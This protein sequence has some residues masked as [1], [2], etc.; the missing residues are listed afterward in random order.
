MRQHAQRLY[1]RIGTKFDTAAGAAVVIICINLFVLGNGYEYCG[2]VK[3]SS[4]IDKAI[5][6]VNT[7]LG[8]TLAGFLHIG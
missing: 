5:V 2:S 8:L 3:L 4:P 6:A 7:G 1:G